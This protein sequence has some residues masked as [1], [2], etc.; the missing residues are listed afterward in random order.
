MT[1]R[2][3]PLPALIAEGT[4]PALA[5]PARTKP[6]RHSR[7]WPDPQ[8]NEHRAEL[9]RALASRPTPPKAT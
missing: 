3:G 8:A 5:T 4:R 6:R 2:Y 7:R 9:L 1:E